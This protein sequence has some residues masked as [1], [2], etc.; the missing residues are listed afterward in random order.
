MRLLLIFATFLFCSAI[1]ANP[2]DSAT[3]KEVLKE[4]DNGS[5]KETHQTKD[6]P[7][8]IYSTL[9]KKAKERFRITDNPKKYN[10]G[11]TVMEGDYQRLLLYAAYTDGY[12][13]IAYER[14]GFVSNTHVLL[15]KYNDRKVLSIDN[16][17]TSSHK[18]INLLAECIRAPNFRWD[19]SDF[20]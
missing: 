6:I 14:G 8:F 4:I 12:Y 15:I 3:L 10:G 11:D 9:R 1:H 18:S 13:I 7:N 17:I 19:Y 2:I 5:F 20:F 16:F